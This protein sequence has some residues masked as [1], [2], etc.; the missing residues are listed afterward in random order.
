MKNVLGITLLVGAATVALLS[1]PPA[2]SSQAQEECRPFIENKCGTC[3]FAN[4]ICPG[5][6]KNKGSMAWGK[7]V[8]DMVELGAKIN[9]EEKGQLTACLARPQA[10]VKELCANP[11]K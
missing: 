10:Q 7:V 4:Y 8:D 5:V 3:H 1:P 2:S 11:V 6:T 9:K